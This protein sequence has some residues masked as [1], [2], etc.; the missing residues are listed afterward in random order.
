MQKSLEEM[1]SL[2]YVWIALGE[3]A[4]KDNKITKDEY[5]LIQGFAEKIEKYNELLEGVLVDG[6]I[7]GRE[8]YHLFEAKYDILLYTLKQA[9]NDDNVTKDEF[10]LIE[11]IKEFLNMIEK[12]EIESD[13]L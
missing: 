9:R 4:L 11:K 7:D 5:V 3:F 13:T 6:I 1:L 12:L 2:T 10:G 8:R